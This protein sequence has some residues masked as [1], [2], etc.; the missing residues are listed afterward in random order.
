MPNYYI[1]LVNGNDANDGLGPYKAA[2]TSGGTTPIAVGDTVTGGTSGQTAKVVYITV[3]S[4]SWAGGDAAGSIYVGTPS[5][6]F[7]NGEALLV[8]GS[9]LATLTADFAVSSWLTTAGGATA[10]RVAPGDEIRYKKTA[11][12]VSMGNATF[13]KRST[14][15]TFAGNTWLYVDDCESAWTA[16][17]N[18]TQS[19]H[20]TYRKQGSYSQQFVFG[21]SF[22]TGK[23]AYHALGSTIDFSAYQN[24]TLWI[25]VSADIAS[26]VFR[27]D[28]CSDAA[29]N[30][31]VNSFTIGALGYD[32]GEGWNRVFLPYGAALGS[33]IQSIALVALSDPG[34]PTIRLDS[35][36]ACNE[37]HYQCVLGKQNEAQLYMVE[38]LSTDRTTATLKN[39]Y[40]GTGETVACYAY[41]YPIVTNAQ[42]N[43]TYIHQ[44]QEDGASGN[45]TKYRFGWNFS[46]DAQDGYTFQCN[47]GTSMG[48]LIYPQDYNR[49][50][51]VIGANYYAGVYTA[52]SAIDQEHENVRFTGCDIVQTYNSTASSIKLLEG[53][54]NCFIVNNWVQLDA[55]VTGTGGTTYPKWTGKIYVQGGSGTGATL[56][57]TGAGARIQGEI[58]I[59]QVGGYSAISVSGGGWRIAKIKLSPS[60]S[61]WPF[62]AGSSPPNVYIDHVEFDCGAMTLYGCYVATGY[63]MGRY[64]IGRVTAVDTTP[65]FA[66]THAFSSNGESPIDRFCIDNFFTEGRFFGS[67]GDGGTFGDHITMGQTAGWAYGGSGLSLLLN[68]VSTTVAMGYEVWLPVAASTSYTL[69]FQVRKTSSGANCT[70]VYDLEG[71]GITALRDQ[72]VTLTDSW[73]EHVSSEVA[74]TIGGWIRL[75]FRALDGSTTG[76]IGIDEIKLVEVV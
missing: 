54:Y 58:T 75:E 43:G 17:A 39:A 53:D 18:V 34:T 11:D 71:C 64:H 74:T 42:A 25:H 63:T 13:T 38:V 65:T 67:G 62:M 14:T 51:Y 9:D 4:G 50:E 41:G 47:V 52:G 23:A 8:G 24:L 29:G 16:S 19:D 12:A 30:T 27:L 1:D 21:S 36:V 5:G 7:T 68:P 44:F 45:P 55:Q 69:S 20:T 3:T 33:S 57:L 70:L 59:Y 49:I 15:L 56:Y 61:Q 73:A 60:S 10:A 66:V 6:A 76:D 40:Y 35:I 31:P 26:G 72:S 22:T 48:R 37:V 28:L 46:T 2:Y 32:S